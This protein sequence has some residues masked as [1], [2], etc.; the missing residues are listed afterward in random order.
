MCLEEEVFNYYAE[1]YFL[2]FHLPREE[3]M[4][5]TRFRLR[6]LSR[7]TVNMLAVDI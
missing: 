7:M 6:D 4:N 5:K 2:P 3:K 1:M